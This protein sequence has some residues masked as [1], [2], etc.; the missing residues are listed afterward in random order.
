MIAYVEIQSHLAYQEAS[1]VV[2]GHL[3]DMVNSMMQNFLDTLDLTIFALTTYI[4]TKND[5]VKKLAEYYQKSI[6]LCSLCCE[7]FLFMAYHCFV[8]AVNF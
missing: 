4:E 1:Y 2:S 3:A 5:S 7:T 6:K 8:R